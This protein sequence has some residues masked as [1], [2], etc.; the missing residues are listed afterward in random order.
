MF[1]CYAFLWFPMLSHA[2]LVCSYVF[3][4]LFF[5]FS[6]VFPVLSVVFLCV[7]LFSYDFPCSSYVFLRFSQAFAYMLFPMSSTTLLSFPSFSCVLL[8]ISHAFRSCSVFF[9]GRPMLF[10]QFHVFAN[11]YQMN[12]FV[13]PMHVSDALLLWLPTIFLHLPM[14]CLCLP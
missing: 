1:R 5:C 13:F 12:F 6:V 2:F 14:F 4:V 9:L 3:P 10:R 11:V 7:P 8:C